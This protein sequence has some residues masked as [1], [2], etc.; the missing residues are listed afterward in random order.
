MAILTHIEATLLWGMGSLRP[1][2]GVGPPPLGDLLYTTKLGTKRWLIMN[3]YS[4]LECSCSLPSCCG[5]AW[6]VD[7]PFFKIAT[8][9]TGTQDQITK[10]KLPSH[11]KVNR[12]KSIQGGAHFFSATSDWNPEYAPVNTWSSIERSSISPVSVMVARQVYRPA[13]A[14]CTLFSLSPAGTTPYFPPG[15]RTFLKNRIL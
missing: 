12:A 14:A 5:R 6:N 7:N 10:K 1:W 8:P 15:N 9:W 3:T 2:S 11:K 4:K 13:S